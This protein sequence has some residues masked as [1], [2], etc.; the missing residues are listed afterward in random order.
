M[1]ELID[2]LIGLEEGL[3]KGGGDLYRERLAEDALL[4]VP[5]AV[6]TK[7]ETAAAIEASPRWTSVSIEDPRLV[8][9]GEGSALVIYRASARRDGDAGPYKALVGSA[10]VRRDGDWELAF[11]QQTPLAD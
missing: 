7:E 9:L 3:W 4:I 11:H 5:G 2:M 6:L 8:E 10:Y 1:A